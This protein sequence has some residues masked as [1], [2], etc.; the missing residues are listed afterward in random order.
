MAA[1]CVRR[2][3]VK[4]IFRAFSFASAPL[5]TKNTLLKSRP[6]KRIRRRAARARTS[7]GT[8]LLWKLNERAC[9]LSARVHSG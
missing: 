2:V 7:T 9:S 6:E 3:M 5:L 4:A 1:T 8:A